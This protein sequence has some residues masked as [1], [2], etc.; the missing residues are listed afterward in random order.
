LIAGITI[1]AVG[2]HYLQ[3]P[4]QRQSDVYNP[5]GYDYHPPSTPYREG[6]HE[7]FGYLDGYR[8]DPVDIPMADSWESYGLV[9]QAENMREAYYEGYLTGINDRLKE[10]ESQQDD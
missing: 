3:S 1:L 9:E 10:I 2:V 6:S 8:G 7:W 5:S 4:P